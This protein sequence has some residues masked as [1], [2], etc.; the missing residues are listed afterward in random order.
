MSR[1]PP[2]DLPNAEGSAKEMLEGV[3]AQ[4]GATP[5]MFTTMAR[6]K[7]LP[8]YLALSGALRGG[9]IRAATGERI[10]LALAEANGCS[11]CLSAHSYLAANVGKLDEGEIERARRFESQDPRAGAILAFAKAVLD[12]HGGVTDT[13]IDAAYAAGLSDEELAETVGHV[14]VNVLT[15]YFNKAFDVDVDFPVVEPAVAGA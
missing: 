15:N 11:Y 13:D 10:A 6:S 12:S 4:L 2:L 7:V 3:R 9:S 14:A 5:N 8:G 1:I